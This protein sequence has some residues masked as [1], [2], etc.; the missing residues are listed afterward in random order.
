MP[1][2]FHMESNE[3]I[4]EITDE[5]LKFLVDNL[6][7]EH[8]KDKDYYICRDTLE[9]LKEN[10]CDEKLLA[11]LEGAMGDGDDVDVAWE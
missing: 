5:Q 6:E 4:G 11:L 9:M 8:A 10:G 3:T 1:R 7:E 2:L